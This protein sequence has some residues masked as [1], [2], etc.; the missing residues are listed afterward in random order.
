MPDGITIGISLQ[1]H[2]RDF[3]GFSRK[4]ASALFEVNE[5]ARGHCRQNH[6]TVTRNDVGDPFSLHRSRERTMRANVRTANVR[7]VQVAIRDSIFLSQFSC[8][9]SATRHIRSRWENESL[10]LSLDHLR[11]IHRL[12]YIYSYFPRNLSSW[13]L[14]LHVPMLSALFLIADEITVH[15]SLARKRAETVDRGRLRSRQQ[16]HGGCSGV[17]KG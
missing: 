9:V 16:F 2:I 15:C 8:Q 10:S 4:T 1:L 13:L 7:A 12:P 17:R 6:K 11:T 14:L 3:Y 5:R